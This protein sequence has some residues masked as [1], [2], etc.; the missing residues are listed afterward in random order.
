MSDS[1]LIIIVSFFITV[2][3]T[4]I[5]SVM[6]RR[7][8]FAKAGADSGDAAESLSNAAAKQIE[9]YQK[10]IVVPLRE[11]IEQLTEQLSVVEEDRYQEQLKFRAEIKSLQ[12]KTDK[13]IE[14]IEFMKGELRRADSSLEFVVS[15]VQDVFPKESEKALRIRRGQL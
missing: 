10:E 2:A 11:R 12:T 9:I 6:N 3:T 7:A 5:A 1:V 8:V 13:L 14:Q 15:V 4:I